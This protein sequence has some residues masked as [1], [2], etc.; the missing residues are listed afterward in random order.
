[1]NSFVHIDNQK[2]HILI[3]GI[4]PTDVLGLHYN[5][6]NSYIFVNVAEI[7]KFKDFENIFVSKDFSAD[8]MKTTGLCGHVYPSLS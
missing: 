8:N 5:R 2:K 3:F 7:Q 4:G 1:M 6:V